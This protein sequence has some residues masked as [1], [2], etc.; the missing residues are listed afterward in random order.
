MGTGST[1]PSWEG[2]AKHHSH[3]MASES[4]SQEILSKFIQPISGSW[5]GCCLCLW[6]LQVGPSVCAEHKLLYD[7][8][9]SMSPFKH[10][11]PV[12]QLGAS[13]LGPQKVGELGQEGFW[14]CQW[15]VPC[16]P[17]SSPPGSGLALAPLSA[18]TTPEPRI[19][20]SPRP[21]YPSSPWPMMSPA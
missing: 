1:R 6:A 20:P 16:V 12:C 19:S 13:S 14:T 15:A 8:S 18:R 21:P 10:S 9:S 2:L 11:P 3:I 17:G 4:Q 7:S 5:H